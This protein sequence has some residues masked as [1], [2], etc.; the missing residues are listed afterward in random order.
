MKMK[1]NGWYRLVLRRETEEE[2]PFRI[3][4]VYDSD[5]YVYDCQL[6]HDEEMVY[7]CCSN[8]EIYIARY[9]CGN[10]GCKFKDLDDGKLFNFML[11]VAWRPMTIKLPSFVKKGLKIKRK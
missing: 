2:N 5:E 8:G 1:S 7:V 4:P 10:G 3:D 9:E 11:I 6:P